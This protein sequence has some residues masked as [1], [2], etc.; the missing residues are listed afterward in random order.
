MKIGRNLWGNLRLDSQ[1]R[2][3]VNIF[4]Q[5]ILRSQ[6][7]GSIGS[8]PARKKALIVFSKVDGLARF[9]TYSLY[10]AAA[11]YKDLIEACRSILQNNGVQHE[12]RQC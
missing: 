3:V 11:L 10:D 9:N 4:Q 6:K 1:Y 8:V 2:C 7:D 5:A 12:D